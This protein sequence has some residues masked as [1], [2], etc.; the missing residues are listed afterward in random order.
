VYYIVVQKL[1]QWQEFQPM[2]RV[3]T[4]YFDGNW[5][6]IVDIVPRFD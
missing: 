4:N 3:S 5:L 2:A 1:C 6:Y